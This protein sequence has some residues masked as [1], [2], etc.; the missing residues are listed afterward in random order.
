[1]KAIT[2]HQP[3]AS[4]LTLGYK[5]YETRSWATSYRG[6]ILIHAGRNA[7]H[8]IAMSR[9]REAGIMDGDSDWR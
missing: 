1:M 8:I 9:Y 6:P 4:L 5:G 3:W 7:E 2:V